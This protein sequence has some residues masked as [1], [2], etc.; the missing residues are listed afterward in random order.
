MGFLRGYTLAE[1]PEILGSAILSTTKELE[2]ELKEFIVSTL[3][4]E[5]IEPEEIESEQVL[6]GEG[7]GLDSIDALELAVA[8]NKEFGLEIE[9]DSEETRKHFTSVSSLA[10]MIEASRN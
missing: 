8:L 4:L 2:S 6:F 3:A 5:D 9:G 1:M 7:L 10:K